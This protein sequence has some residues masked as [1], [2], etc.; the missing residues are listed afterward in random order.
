MKLVPENVEYIVI[1][2]SHTKNPKPK[3]GVSKLNLLHRMEGAF[4]WSLEGPACRHHF[5]VRTDGAVEV[6]RPLDTPGN[7]TYGVN[8]RSVSVCY[9]GG[10]TENGFPADTRTDA[11]RAA[12]KELV[13][14]LE[15]QFPN[16]KAIC[17]SQLT[18]RTA[19]GCPGFSMEQL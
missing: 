10:V 11:Q 7:H 3:D 13:K 8:D 16:A 1:H 15:D 2:S 17:H 18:P 19:R 4:S 6:G 5:V 9:M 12:L 14:R